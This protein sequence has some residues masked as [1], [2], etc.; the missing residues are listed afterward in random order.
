MKTL[1][2]QADVFPHSF[3]LFQ[4]QQCLSCISITCMVFPNFV[5]IKAR[6]YGKNAIC[7]LS[8]YELCTDTANCTN[9]LLVRD[10]DGKISSRRVEN[11]CDYIQN[12][13]LLQYNSKFNYAPLSQSASRTSASY[14]KLGKFYCSVIRAF[15]DLLTQ[16][17]SHYITFKNII[18]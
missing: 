8:S 4:F 14:Y 5:L 3:S 2:P 18:N 16:N 6:V 15:Y 10:I 9:L 1:C 7:S 13:I 11:Q 17:T 12:G